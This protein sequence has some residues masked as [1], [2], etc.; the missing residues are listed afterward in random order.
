MEDRTRLGAQ[1]LHVQTTTH[2]SA[3]GRQGCW[4][5]GLG[6]VH[7]R[8]AFKPQPMR[9]LAGGKGVG[10]SDSAQCTAAPR[11]NRNLCE[12][13]REARVLEPRTRLGAKPLCVQTAT[14]A[15]A[16]GRLGCWRLG[17]GSVR[18]RSA[19]KLQ[20]MRAL[21]GGKGVGGSDSARCAAA[22]RSNRNPCERWR[23]ARVLEHRTRLSAQPLCVQT[24][25]HA[26]AG[27]RLGC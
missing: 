8:S 1:P 4:S 9:A 12:R 25:T 23:E 14:Y 17:L 2:A 21:A 5:L 22:L 16:G 27:G 6:S 10:A 15:S 24:A 19:F 20:P 18:S 3:G 7:S 13:W 11:S 26:S